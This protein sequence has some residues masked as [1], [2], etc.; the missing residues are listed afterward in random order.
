V[1]TVWR[2][3]QTIAVAIPGRQAAWAATRPAQ[4][5]AAA[6]TLMIPARVGQQCG[7]HVVCPVISDQQP[8]P[9]VVA[10]REQTMQAGL[11]DLGLARPSHRATPR[12][13]RRD[14]HVER[15]RS[16]R[17]SLVARRW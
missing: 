5:A 17:V 10:D 7:Q 14:I 16:H 2:S 6:V 4:W 11:I 12:E 3:W 9:R 8:Y 1:G 15:C 13:K